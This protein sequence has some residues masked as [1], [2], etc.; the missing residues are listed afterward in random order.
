MFSPELIL[1]ILQLFTNHK[2]VTSLLLP[3]EDFSSFRSENTCFNYSHARA[4]HA[5]VYGVAITGY[6]SVIW[7]GTVFNYAVSNNSPWTF[8]NLRLSYL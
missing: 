8:K 4:P 5:G 7:E 1:I 6:A 2:N 3:L